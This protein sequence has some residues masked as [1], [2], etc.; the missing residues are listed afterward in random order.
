MSDRPPRR[1]A[2]LYAAAVLLAASPFAFGFLSGEFAGRGPP[3]GSMVELRVPEG[4]G[5]LGIARLLEDAELIGYA[6]IF[7]AYARITGAATSL[8]AGRYEIPRGASYDHV[9]GALRRGEVA[10]VPLTIPEGLRLE[11]VA[12]RLAE[13][14]GE[15]AETVVA[16][17]ADPARVAELGVPGPTLEGY[18]FP[19]TYRFAE[20]TGVPAIVT[21]M[22]RRYHDFWGEEERAR[23]AALGFDERE[24]VTLASIVEKEVRRDDERAIVAGVYWNRLEL[25]MPLQADP[26]VQYALG[27]RR[28]RLLYRDIDAVADHPYNTYTHPGLPPGPI[29]SPGARSLRAA[30][31][32]AA[33]DYLFFVARNDGAHEFSATLREHNAAIRRIRRRTRDAT[34]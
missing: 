14:A 15:P 26:T 32:P 9:L 1:R 8:K 30:L 4:L 34:R 10:T 16:Y 7:D 31:Q 11:E 6:R 33:H 19:E 21:A 17:L 28:S 29:A 2:G 20:G 13:Y 24:T 3:D 18:V 12:V 27:E 22:V 5:S 23:A 25:G